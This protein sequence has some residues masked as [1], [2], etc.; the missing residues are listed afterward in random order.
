M[1]QRN[2]KRI[3]WL[4]M[5]IFTLGITAAI[6]Y[7]S[8]ASWGQIESSMFDPGMPVNAQLKTLRC[9]LIITSNE[10]ATVSATFE[11]P[12]DMARIRT[13]RASISEGYLT[14]RREITTNLPLEPGEV[15]TLKW[16]VSA[17]DAAWDRYVFV[18]VF[19]PRSTALMPAQTK[20]CGILVVHWPWIRGQ[21]IANGL[22]ILGLLGTVL[23]FG[24]WSGVYWPFTNENLQQA[25]VMG[26]LTALVFTGL[27]LSLIGQWIPHLL[28]L[29]IL[30]FMLVSLATRALMGMGEPID[31]L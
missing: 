29:I 15:R 14:L 17:N 4:G 5:A 12:T 16:E 27:Y 10:V 7:Q 19:T 3:G 25:Y 28:L 20:A 30:L 8:I 26:I 31:S 21:F 24:I 11:N 9:P 1:I 2:K 13:V 6:M 18:R 22:L 23:G